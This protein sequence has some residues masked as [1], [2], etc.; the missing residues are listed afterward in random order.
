MNI[1]D[2]NSLDSN[3][4][5]NENNEIHIKFEI[6]LKEYYLKYLKLFSVK[7]KKRLINKIK[8]YDIDTGSVC[9]KKN[10]RSRRMEMLGLWKKF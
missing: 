4:K 9:A 3:D 7:D 10:D 8:K 1:M 2:I 5:N 6:I